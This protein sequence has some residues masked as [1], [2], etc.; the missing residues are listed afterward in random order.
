MYVLEIVIVFLLLLLLY[1]TGWLVRIF[2]MLLTRILDFSRVF[3]ENFLK[4]QI[5]KPVAKKK[6]KLNKKATKT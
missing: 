5:E 4:E 3:L 6:T 1:S 2:Q